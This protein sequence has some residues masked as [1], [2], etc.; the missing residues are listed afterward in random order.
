MP[1][2]PGRRSRQSLHHEARSLASPRSL[3]VVGRSATSGRLRSDRSGRRKRRRISLIVA[4]TALIVVAILVWIP[5]GRPVSR[6]GLSFGRFTR[7]LRP[8]APLSPQS[9]RYVADFVAQYRSHFG[10]VGVN[11][12]PIWVAG[13]H[14]PEVAVRVAPGCHDF[15]RNTGR[16]IPIPTAA[17]TTGTGDSPLVVYQPSTH[18][19]WELWRAVR[20][21]DGSWRACWGGRLDARS[22]AGV[23]PYPYGLAASGISYLA[24]DITEADIRSG[25]IR[26]ALAVQMPLCGRPPVPP[27]DRTDCPWSQANPPYGTWYRFPATMPLPRHLNHF[28]RMV[29]FAIRS[30]G[31]VLT[32]HAGAVAIVVE[33]RIDWR[34]KR[35]DGPNPMTQSW[36]GLPGYEVLAGLPWNRLEV[37]RPTRV[38]ALRG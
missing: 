35:R 34:L 38:R 15:L 29:F 9:A 25:A 17:E 36:G 3:A 27:A 23:F 2:Y 30:Y 22:S 31:M 21:A 28:A 26:H 19:D 16:R 13:P 18:L 12:Q 33:S 32:D 5:V 37:L 10:T 4:A 8:D 1:T 7:L 20:Q 24:T 11:Q 14:Q 6:A